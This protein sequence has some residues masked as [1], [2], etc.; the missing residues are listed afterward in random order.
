MN[1]TRDL[2][3][4]KATA[5]PE[6]VMPILHLAE[7]LRPDAVIV[8]D[9]DARPL[10]Y[11]LEQLAKMNCTEFPLHDKIWYR[12]ISKKLA[13]NAIAD[14]CES[15][16]AELRLIETP[17]LLV[18][19]D[20]ISSQATTANLFRAATTYAGLGRANITWATLT[21]RGTALNIKPYASPATEAPWRDRVE[22]LGID[23]D[24][25]E[26]IEMPTNESR[27]FYSAIE[28]AARKTAA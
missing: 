15:I 25:I 2:L 20:H 4:E 23:Y 6:T 18:I 17:K 10:G 19:D 11:A 1:L 27:E 12:R 21:G 5:L 16:F 28:E 3:I 9:R 14:H 7:T 13:R 8:C 22:I 26:L 24:G